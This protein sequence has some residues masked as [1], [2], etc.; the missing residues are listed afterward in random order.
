MA[1][2]RFS[3]LPVGPKRDLPF[4]EGVGAVYHLTGSVSLLIDYA[5]A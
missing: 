1:V 3:R 2:S 5:M 4:P